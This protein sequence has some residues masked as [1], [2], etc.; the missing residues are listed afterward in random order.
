MDC[1]SY[2]LSDRLTDGSG[3]V[4]VTEGRTALMVA[5][6]TGA[7]SVALALM[8][9]CDV[10]LERADRHGFTAAHIAGLNGQFELLQLLMAQG[11]NMR[12]LTNCGET[13]SMLYE[14]NGDAMPSPW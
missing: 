13:P 14:R 4:T 7:E 9:A 10:D 8:N 12:A 11:A 3:G 1:L 6:E 2:T 5:A